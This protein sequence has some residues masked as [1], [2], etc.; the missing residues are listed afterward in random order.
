MAKSRN[1]PKQ[2]RKSKT[3][4]VF[5]RADRLE[6]AGNL[7]AA[8]RLFLA[9]AKAGDRACQLNVGN[10]Y[11]DGKGIRRNRD[12]A[13]YWYKRAYRR[14]ERCAAHNI[15]ILWR[16]ERE[17]R[18]ALSWFKRAVKMGDDEANLEVAKYYLGNENSS[19]KAIPHL[20][21]VCRSNWVTEA[22]AEEAERLLNKP[23]RN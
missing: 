3:D 6:D 1:S 2:S 17:P 4:D 20:E 10:Y 7:K 21:R 19:S 15:G 5:I 9:G 11:D 16:N 14:G 23:E 22:G 12:A 8:F 13:L 18:R